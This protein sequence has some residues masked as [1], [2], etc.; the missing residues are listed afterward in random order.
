MAYYLSY[1]V[2]IMPGGADGSELTLYQD[3]ETVWHGRGDKI[4]TSAETT[5]DD[6]L[7]RIDGTQETFTRTCHIEIDLTAGTGRLAF[8]N[9]TSFLFDVGTTLPV[10][11]AQFVFYVWDC[12]RAAQWPSTLTPLVTPN[13]IGATALG[14]SSIAVEHSQVENAEYYSLDYN[15]TGS[16]SDTGSVHALTITP[17]GNP[18]TTIITTVTGLSADTIYYFRVQALPGDSEYYSPSEWSEIASATT[19]SESGNEEEEEEEEEGG[20]GNT[21]DIHYKSYVDLE[22]APVMP[23]HAATKG[24]VDSHAASGSL[25]VPTQ[26]AVGYVFESSANATASGTWTA[27]T[28][29]VTSGSTALVTSGGVYTAIAALSSVYA[30]ISHNHAAGNITSGTLAAA[31]LPAAT[32]SALGAIK[33]GAG[34]SVASGVL[35]VGDL[36][37]V[38]AVADHEH[39]ASDVGAVAATDIVTA[40]SAS[41]NN[42]TVPGALAVYSFVNTNYAAKSH[43]HA[44]AQVTGLG[45]AATKNTGIA[46]GNIPILDTNGK[47]VKSVIPAV[48]ISNTFT[49]A[50]QTAML[51]LSSAEE[52]DIAIRTDLNKTFILTSSAANAYSTLANWQELLTPTD[53]VSSVNG[54]TGAVMLTA[55]NVS[56][57]AASALVTSV[58]STSTDTTVPSAKAVYTFVNSHYA[59]VNHNHAAGEITSGILS[60]ARIPVATSSA[61]GGVKVGSGLSITAG[62]LSVTV[63]RSGNYSAADDSLPVT[64]KAVATYADTT[65]AK[66][67]HNHGMLAGPAAVFNL[68]F[69]LE[70]DETYLATQDIIAPVYSTTATYHV[71]DYVTKEGILYR[72][73]TAVSTAGAFDDAKW[74]AVTVMESVNVIANSSGRYDGTITGN[75]TLT[76]FTLTHNLGTRNVFVEMIDSEYNQVLCAVQ[77]TSA[78]SVTIY[79]AEAPTASETY[80]VAIRS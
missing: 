51:A 9:G 19:E 45:T 34:L 52:G 38:Y 63:A 72:C 75:G 12:E 3:A 47:L 15:T 23:T 70:T 61:I 2:K 4:L 64:M 79:F 30:P 1:A 55:A 43:T 26:N 80:Y 60:P 77:K 53:A 66:S 11:S 40:I 65:Y 62:L 21:L 29:D 33:V 48:A 16:F 35:S 78:N 25:H 54:Q 73:V 20:G 69:D 8:T 76:E 5:W 67:S 37:A 10:K 57:I 42:T 68:P 22:R 32:T 14:P 27:Y 58:A 49:A 46:S 17:N 41:S 39:T 13:M 74:S 24:Y 7:T 56:A 71:G 59:P 44:A 18:L 36:S 50:N 28:A 31:R 6:T